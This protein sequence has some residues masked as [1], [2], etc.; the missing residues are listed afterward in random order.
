MKR[1]SKKDLLSECM[2]SIEIESTVTEFQTAFCAQCLNPICVRSE[3]ID[4]KWV[5]RM[6]R[7]AEAL[8]DTAPL[9]QGA[10]PKHLDLE[11][12]D[13]V[14]LDAEEARLQSLRRWKT[15]GAEIKKPIIHYADP[16]QENKSSERLEQSVKA[17]SKGIDSPKTDVDE[18]LSQEATESRETL[19][20]IPE[21]DPTPS[22]P[23]EPVSPKVETLSPASNKTGNQNGIML[24]SSDR[25]VPK[26]SIILPVT[27]KW[28]IPS[29]NEGKLKV[30]ISD[31]KKIK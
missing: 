25:E 17:L 31:G 24:T 14:S 5:A 10:S 23:P 22:E 3:M 20:E 30:R 16:P 2:S 18:S 21:Q 19:A 28:E 4:S 1:V 26:P 11:V 6:L 13:F 15:V 27:D 9:F 12:K 8:Q 7:Q 29:E